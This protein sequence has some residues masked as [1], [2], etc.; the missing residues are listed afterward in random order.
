MCPLNE[1]DKLSGGS[2][3]F[4]GKRDFEKRELMH[5]WKKDETHLHSL[6]VGRL[7]VK[8]GSKRKGKKGLKLTSSIKQLINWKYLR[9]SAFMLENSEVAVEHKCMLYKVNNNILHKQSAL[10]GSYTVN[11]V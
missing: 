9:L 10:G 8:V 2:V 6:I 4:D 3:N 11:D 7:Q 1:G 5:K